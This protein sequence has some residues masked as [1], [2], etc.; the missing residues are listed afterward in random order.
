MRHVP[1]YAAKRFKDNF[2]SKVTSAFC[3]KFKLIKME[4]TCC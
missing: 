2:A 1:V 3:F 4:T